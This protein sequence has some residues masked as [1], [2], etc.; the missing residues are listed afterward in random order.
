MVE[1]ILVVDDD[2]QMTSFLERFLAKQGFDV[3]S[4]G[5]ATQMGLAMEHHEFDLVLLDVGLPDIDG[6]EVTRELR[7]SSRLPIILL[8]A[9]DEVFD[10]II[11]LEMG[12]DDYVS[13]PFEPRELLARIR[14][15]LRRS[16]SKPETATAL[17]EVRCIRFMGFVLDLPRRHLGAP[18]SST[19]PLTSME[20][21]LLRLLVEHAGSVVSRD[22]MMK[23][24][25][26]NSIHTTDRAIDAHIAR[27]RKKLGG[28]EN[29]DELIRTVHGAGYTLAASVHCE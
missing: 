21:I 10:K 4:V 19:V 13:K 7:R 5:S 9:R 15:V 29:P 18:D 8:T 6:F 1:R 17:T 26:G 23:S 20:F 28:H 2:R 22:R 3:H 12:A 16:K 24:L 11:G 14:S 27:L 25:Y